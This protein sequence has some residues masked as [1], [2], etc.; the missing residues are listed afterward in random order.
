MTRRSL[1]ATN[2]ERVDLGLHPL[3]GQ[4]IAVARAAHRHGRRG[5]ERRP[6]RVERP[7]GEQQQRQRAEAGDGGLQEQRGGVDGERA[8]G[9]HLLRRLQLG[10]RAAREGEPQRRHQ[11]AER[12]DQRDADLDR[13]PDVAG[14]ERLDEHADAGRAEDEQQ[15]GQRRQGEVRGLDHRSDPPRSLMVAATAGSIRFSSGCG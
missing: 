1:A 4:L 10:P 6:G 3:G 2:S 8:G 15:R 12:A 9:G 11:A 13:V 14:R 7:L 5:D